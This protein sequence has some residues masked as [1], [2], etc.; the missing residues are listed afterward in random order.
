MEELLRIESTSL[1]IRDSE[2]ARET[3]ERLAQNKAGLASKFYD[4]PAGKDNRWSELHPA[5]FLP[6]MACTATKQFKKAREVIGLTSPPAVACYDMTSI[7]MG[8][9]VTPRGWME[10]GNMASTKLRVSLFNINNAAKS[11][12]KTGESD[13]V[14]MKSIDKFE[15]A[16]RT[17]RCA[18]HFSVNW[19]YSFV[20]LEN[21]LWNRKF[22][23]EELCIACNLQ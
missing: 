23:S 1:R 4:V 14:E 12:S 15:L 22:C 6:A 16:L 2:K 5:R 8:D 11:S 3:E 10:I 21:F 20:A 19:N 9:F 17:M 18:A 7:G 13:E